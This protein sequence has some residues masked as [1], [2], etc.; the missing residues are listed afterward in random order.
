MTT[1]TEQTPTAPTLHRPD[2]KVDPE[3]HHAV[4][5]TQFNPALTFAVAWASAIASLSAA[6]VAQT[7]LVTSAATRQMLGSRAPRPPQMHFDH[8]RPATE[9]AT[10]HAQVDRPTGPG[11]RRVRRSPRTPRRC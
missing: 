9:G 1:D 6:L 5:E 7:Q 2:L 3:R 11:R 10:A 4:I 8:E